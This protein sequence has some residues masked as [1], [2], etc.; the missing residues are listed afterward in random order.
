MVNGMKKICLLLVLVLVVCCFGACGGS[1]AVESTE[2]S[3]EL[4]TTDEVVIRIKK[5]L[6]VDETAFLKELEV[7]DGIT[8][9]STDELLLLNMNAAT[10][11][12]LVAG[13]HAEALAD[14]D[15]F[16]QEEGTY[17]EK[18]D[19]DENFRTVKV[20]VNRQG[21]DSVSH[22]KLEYIKYAAVAMEYQMYLPNGQQTTVEMIYSD[23]GEVIGVSSL[24]NQIE[25]SE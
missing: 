8:A 25:L 15:A 14:Y 5:D 10:Y 19:Y 12:K 23:T 2:P 13:K 16:L 24:P 21:Y 4:T 9:E 3:T 18:F 11:D 1:G 7:Y 6:I 17:I 22:D 20:Y